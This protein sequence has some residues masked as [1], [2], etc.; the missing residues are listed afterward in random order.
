MKINV[1]IQFDR[2][3]IKSCYMNINID[4]KFDILSLDSLKYS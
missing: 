2:M 3:S 1:K 4:I